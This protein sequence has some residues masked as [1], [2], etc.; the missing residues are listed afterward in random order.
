MAD[1]YILTTGKRK[2]AT[3]KAKITTG[4]GQ[5]FINRKPLEIYEPEVARLKIQ[6]ALI[7]AGDLANKV[8]IDV[9]VQGG[10]VI[11]Q[12]AAVRMAIARGLIK[13]F[14]DT[15]LEGVY[16]EYDRNLLVID[17]RR[18]L[19]KKPGGRGARKKRQ[20]SYR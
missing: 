1:E 11:G 19:P 9:H 17:P 16:K 14:K 12:S 3:A 4:N 6:E 18:K 13:F 8:N 7:L 15:K 10:G 5:V 2:T 20:K